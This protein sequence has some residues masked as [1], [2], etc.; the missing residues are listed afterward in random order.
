MPYSIVAEKVQSACW[1]ACL[2]LEK[3]DLGDSAQIQIDIIK[4]AVKE[5]SNREYQTGD[6]GQH[7][8]G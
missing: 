1:E 7:W 5:P 6:H 2:E 4:D 8:H 3:L